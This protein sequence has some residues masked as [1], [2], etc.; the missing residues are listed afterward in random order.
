MSV[1]LAKRFLT[2]IAT[3][4]GATVLTF[5]ALEILPGD[6]AA[7]ILGIDAPESAIQALRESGVSIDLY[8]SATSH[9]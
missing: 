9:G 8:S 3:L 6:P 4:L 5:L 2:F 1:F 7:G